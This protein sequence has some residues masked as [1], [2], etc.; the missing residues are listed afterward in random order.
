MPGR[1]R[2]PDPSARG[3]RFADALVAETVAPARAP[4]PLDEWSLAERRAR[5]AELGVAG[6]SRMSRADLVRALGPR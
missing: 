2:D 3:D 5:A 4:R 1:I 6:R